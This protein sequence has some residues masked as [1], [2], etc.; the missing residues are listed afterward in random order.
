MVP[1]RHPE[2]DDKRNS[3]A[4]ST[5]FRGA[6]PVAAMALSAGTAQSISLRS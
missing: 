5:D 4:R 1:E 6:R 3:I 2:K